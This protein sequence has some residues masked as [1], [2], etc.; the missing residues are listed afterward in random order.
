MLSLSSKFF[1][2]IYVCNSKKKLMKIKLL[3]SF[4]AGILLITMPATLQAQWCPVNTAIPYNANMPGIT[5]VTVGNIN[6]TSADCENYPNN[7]YVYTGLTLNLVQG[8]MYTMSITHTIDGSICPDMNLRVYIDYNLDGQL[9]DLGEVV[10]STDH[11]L[12]GTPYT[13]SFTV[14]PTTI[15]GATRMRVLAKMS[16]TGGHTPPTPC[17]NPPDPF[18]FHGEIED[19][20]VMITSTTGIEPVNSLSDFSIVP[21]IYNQNFTVKYTLPNPGNIKLN[22][23]DALGKVALTV[24]NENQIAGEH[25]F[26]INPGELKLRAGIYF[27][28]LVSSKEIKTEKFIISQ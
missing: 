24:L 1:E 26:L 9:D 18:G 4:I 8:S 2:A 17:D 6:R 21:D 3:S 19:Y 10:I 12:P 25:S 15:L 20:D 14:P 23:T 5:N 16:A 7:S 22:I 11:H 28:T 27:L 13:A